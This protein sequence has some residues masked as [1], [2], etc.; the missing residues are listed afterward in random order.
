MFG[1]DQYGGYLVSALAITVLVLGGYGWY[2]RSRLSGLKRR[3][4]AQ[5][6]GDHSARN[7]SAAAPMASTAQV[8]N[9]AKGPTTL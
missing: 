9:S 6:G 7:V 2:L 1:L 3:R 4:A 8:A 5:A